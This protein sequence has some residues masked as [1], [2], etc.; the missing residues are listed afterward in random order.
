MPRGIPMGRYSCVD[1]EVDEVDTVTDV[2][3]NDATTGTQARA[4][5]QILARDGDVLTITAGTWVQELHVDGTGPE[6]SN[7][8]PPNKTIQDSSRLRIGFTVR[9]DGS[10]LRHDG[11][12]TD[13]DST[14]PDTDPVR[15][16]MDGD[17]AYERE[18]L[19]KEDGGSQD[20]DVLIAESTLPTIVDYYVDRDEAADMKAYMKTDTGGANDESGAGDG[21]WEMIEKG[22]AY[23]LG[24]SYNARG[25]ASTLNWQ[26]VAVDRV[27]NA[28][29][30]DANANAEDGYAPYVLTVD[31]DSP[32]IARARTGISYDD[33]SVT[34]GGTKYEGKEIKDRSYIMLAFE[35]DGRGG[36]ADILHPASID[37]TRFRLDPAADAEPIA[38]VGVIHSADKKGKGLDDDDAI[39]S[40]A[41]VYLELSRELGSDETPEVEMLAGAVR[42]EA[43]NNN[44]PMVKTP[45]DRIEPGFAVTITADVTGRPV[46][47]DDGE[48]EVAITS[49]EELLR[50]PAV[51]VV[52]LKV[53]GG[54]VKIRAVN[55]SSVGSDGP[56]AWAQT[57]DDSDLPN[58]DDGLYAVIVAG[59]DAARNSGGTAG[60]SGS[61]TPSVEDELDLVKLD[62]AVLLIEKDTKL[63]KADPEF[64]PRLGD[65][66]PIETESPSPFVKLSFKAEGSEVKIDVDGSDK[67]SLIVD[68][69]SVKAKGTTVKLDSHASVTLAAVTLDG[70]AVEASQ[71][72][73]L[74]ANEF[75]VQLNGLDIAKHE[76][77]Y[78]ATDE[79]GNSVSGTV[80]FEV[81]RRPAYKVTL[82]PGWNLIS[83]PGTPV[84]PAIG[85]VIKNG[86]GGDLSVELVLG[87]QG[88]AWQTA[89]RE[90][91][92]WSGTLTTIG[93]G[94]GYWVQSTAFETISTLIS[95]ADTSSTLPTIPVTQGWNLL[96]VMDI[97]QGGAGIAPIGKAEADDY[98]T[99]IPWRVAYSF[100]TRTSAWSKLAPETGVV[101]ADLP[102]APTGT[103]A[104]ADE[105]LNGKGYW[106][107]SSTVGTLV[108]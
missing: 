25:G 37:H 54:K 16:N 108:P 23:S 49:D 19:S 83:L 74:G 51:Y 21:D 8:T 87:Y 80:K 89:I 7:I 31:N 86:D 4:A 77:K 52:S 67:T 99:S 53:V 75:L 12:F 73:T 24:L 66:D 107:W 2:D 10:G 42:D 39:T 62:S 90:D 59:E 43:G 29:Y 44:S 98:F 17:S 65:K 3:G 57:L 55:P 93:G 41:R 78:T 38:V 95:E 45:E 68:K 18:P 82:R 92:S 85:S 76:L 79:L 9:D 88:G 27:G 46:I 34:V 6:F 63:G 36:S 40:S 60:W 50:S 14:N 58:R 69:T 97:Q 71:I 15:S 30:T 84:D 100:D 5:A 64:T 70:E 106:V 28:S 48:F 20:V 35:N 22:K 26:L 33:K 103:A 56:N 72:R 11:E 101:K 32:I 1:G 13:V 61:G 102:G 81:K 96:G 91:A 104:V 94:W 47:G 105:V